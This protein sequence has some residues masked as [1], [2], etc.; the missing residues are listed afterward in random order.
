MNKAAQEGLK[1]KILN[2]VFAYEEGTMT[3]AEWLEHHK[4]NGAKLNGSELMLTDKSFY[5]LKKT[6]IEYFNQLQEPYVIAEWYSA[7]I[8]GH[9]LEAESLEELNSEIIEYCRINFL[10]NPETD[11][12]LLEW[13]YNEFCIYKNGK[14]INL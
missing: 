1:N 6:E 5:N 9:E 2:T 8:D 11:K 4:N 13:I 12:E 14:V 3:R 7:N 10:D